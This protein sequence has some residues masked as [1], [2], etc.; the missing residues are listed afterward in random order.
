MATN[1]PSKKQI[2][3]LRF[4]ETF[5]KGNDYSPSYRE[6][7]RALG[8]KSVSTVASHI[9]QLVTKGY[10]ERDTYSPRSISVVGMTSTGPKSKDQIIAE[11]LQKLES[12]ASDD[13]KQAIARVRE[14]LKSS[15][16]E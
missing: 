14:L 11:A 15:T 13:D 6:I 1:H 16:T 10:L 9:D 4:I 5:T 7:M 12:K 2:E 3:L 8:Y